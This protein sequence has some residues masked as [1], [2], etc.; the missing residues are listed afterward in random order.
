MTTSCCNPLRGHMRFVF[1]I[2][3]FTLKKWKHGIW[4]TGHFLGECNLNYILRTVMSS[5]CGSNFLA[6]G[7]CSMPSR[8]APL[9]PPV[10]RGQ[11]VFQVLNICPIRNSHVIQEE[12]GLQ[13]E[14][15]RESEKQERDTLR[16]ELTQHQRKET[17]REMR[18]LSQCLERKSAKNTSLYHWKSHS[19]R[20]AEVLY[21]ERKRGDRKKGG[22]GWWGETGKERT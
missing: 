2:V 9:R 13:G 4:S 11:W 8:W 3:S 21:R 5:S 1:P 14:G 22:G 6:A 15:K 17:F 20:T 19:P 16:E 7:R 12:E 18:K 10:Y